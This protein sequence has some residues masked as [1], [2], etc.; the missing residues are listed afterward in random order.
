M[1]PFERFLCYDEVLLDNGVQ[2]QGYGLTNRPHPDLPNLLFLSFS[3]FVE[4]H[5]RAKVFSLQTIV[6]VL[7]DYRYFVTVKQ[8]LLCRFIAAVGTR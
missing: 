1:H 4:R 8:G 2:A 3:I 6:A 7:F 5:Y